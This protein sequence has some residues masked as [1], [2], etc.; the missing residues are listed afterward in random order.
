VNL[1]SML[2]V[3]IFCVVLPLKSGDFPKVSRATLGAGYVFICFTPAIIAGHYRLFSRAGRTIYLR[4]GRD[5][6]WMTGQEV[7]LVVIAILA[8]AATVCAIVAG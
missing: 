1:I 4:K 8:A 5:V 6:P 7:F 2:A 3:V